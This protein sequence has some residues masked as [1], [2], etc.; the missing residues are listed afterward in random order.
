MD[1]QQKNHETHNVKRETSESESDDSSSTIQDSRT[2]GKCEEYLAGWKRAQ[3]DYQNL[4]KEVEKERVDFVKYANERLLHELLPSLDQYETAMKHTPELSTLNAAEQKTYRN[5]LQGLQAVRSLWE[6]TLRGL[7]LERIATD[8]PFNPALHDAAGE[9]PSEE[10]K[11][12]EIVRVIHDGWRWGERVIR[13]ARVIVA[14]END[15]SH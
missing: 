5:W 11:P 1:D 15:T 9:E 12:G 6:Q 2:C 10:K 3:A 4:R 8:G 13:P 7:G 14:K